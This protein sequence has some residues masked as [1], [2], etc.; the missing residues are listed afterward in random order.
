VSSQ[1]TGGSMMD[2][3][4]TRPM[5]VSNTSPVRRKSKRRMRYSKRR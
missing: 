2:K 4:D 5:L 1:E 3:A